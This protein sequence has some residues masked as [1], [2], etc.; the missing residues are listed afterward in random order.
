[1]AS[2]AQA[3]LSRPRD[4]GTKRFQ[5]LDKRASCATALPPKILP[6]PIFDS[7]AGSSESKVLPNSLRAVS[8]SGGRVKLL[9]SR[10]TLNRLQ[11]SLPKSLR[12]SQSLT[13][14]K[15]S[16]FRRS[17]TKHI[18][19]M[20]TSLS[21]SVGWP[22]C[23]LTTC[24]SQQSHLLMQQNAVNLTLVSWRGICS[25]NTFTPAQTNRHQFESTLLGSLASLDHSF[26]LN[27]RL[28]L[29]L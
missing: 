20:A 28:C 8:P 6:S 10:S 19:I 23:Q 14:S 4:S 16:I 21:T 27:Q 26:Q 7:E 11:Y 25:P 12:V 3:C 1:V 15:F 9:S 17:L 18:S 5:V 13:P 29:R 24:N 2:T 22:C